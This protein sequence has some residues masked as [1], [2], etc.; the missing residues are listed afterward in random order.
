M[1]NI[2][3]KHRNIRTRAT[4]IAG[5][6]Y[7]LNLAVLMLFFAF[8]KVDLNTVLIIIA[9]SILV[10]A[11]F[12]WVIS[13]GKSEI[14]NDPSLTASQVVCGCAVNLVALALAPQLA[15]AIAINLFIPLAYGSLH[16]RKEGYI[17]AWLLVS[18]AFACVSHIQKDAISVVPRSTT[19]TYLF[20]LV[21]SA[22]LGRFLFINSEV[23]RIRHRLRGKNQS[24]RQAYAQLKKIAEKD[25]NTGMASHQSF[26]NI[27][28]DVTNP[29]LNTNSLFLV[30]IEVNVSPQA[31]QQDSETHERV[32]RAVSDLLSCRL[33]RSDT[34]ARYS[35]NQFAL[36][37][38]EAPK[39]G[40]ISMLQRTYMQIE[41]INWPYYGIEGEIK[42][43][44]GLSTWL[45]GEN[46]E[47]ALDLC[48]SALT[49]AKQ[50]RAEQ[51]SF[52]QAQPAVA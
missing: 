18:I 26:K 15:Y 42:T 36:L 23:S 20:V 7:I 33:R 1:E 50:K 47:Q 39:Q 19:D 52:H 44:I 2:T 34:I 30:L 27:L 37:L 32:A 10:N 9:I 12:I 14:L 13:S 25:L 38:P 8:S 16:F 29:L 48:E 6:D 17:V 24:L 43:A 40:I 21:L 41:D 51:F 45:R 11:F 31:D 46:P 28:Q 22:A 4:L 49:K 5:A 3:L 35:S